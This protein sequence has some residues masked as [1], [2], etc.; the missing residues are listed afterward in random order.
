MRSTYDAMRRLRPL[1]SRGRR[2]P[3]QL[4]ARSSGVCRLSERGGPKLDSDRDI[5]IIVEMQLQRPLAVVASSV[6]VDVLAVLAQADAAFTPPELHRVIGEHSEDGVRRALRMLDQQGIV[7]SERV[8]QA[9]RYRLNRQH[10]AAP[11]L[12]ALAALRQT[13]IDQLRTLIDGWSVP[14]AYAALFGSAAR[15][16]MAVDSDIDLFVVRT[17]GVD[18][19]DQR[20]DDQ[21]DMLE[22]T[23]QAWTGNDV[24]ALQQ[25]EAEV[26]GGLR[27]GRRVLVDIRDHGVRLA[28]TSDI[29]RPTTAGG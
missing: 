29:L 23:T 10:L 25:D 21:I 15:G 18:I 3:R 5:C 13:L 4:P 16:D 6:S 27:A 14:C 1:P 9:G 12:V 8:G 24:R 2:G 17:Q 7:L 20:W 11:H 22:A 28:G 19:G 26:R